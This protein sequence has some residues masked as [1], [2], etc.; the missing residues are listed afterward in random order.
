[1]VLVVVAF[2]IGHSYQGRKGAIRAT[3]AG[4]VMAII[5]LSTNSLVPAMIV[6]AL[7][8]AGSG[9]VG[10]WILREPAQPSQRGFA[11]PSPAGS[12]V[13]V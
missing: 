6:H 8:D 10:Y 5:V 4:A 3:L 11:Q 7:I 2:G 1:M 13:S 12:R 9:T